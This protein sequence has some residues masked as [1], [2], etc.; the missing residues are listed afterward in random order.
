VEDDDD[1]S[2]VASGR[3]SVGSSSARRER[4]LSP[5]LDDDTSERGGAGG[6]RPA[7][8]HRPPP[9]ATSVTP[10]IEAVV[11]AILGAPL[12]PLSASAGAATAS[13]LA[14]LASSVLAAGEAYRASVAAQA[15]REAAVPMVGGASAAV[16]SVSVVAGAADGAAF[17]WAAERDGVPSAASNGGSLDGDDAQMTS[18]AGSAV[19]ASPPPWFAGPGA[20]PSPG[21]PGVGGGPPGSPFGVVRPRRALVAYLGTPLYDSSMPIAPRGGEAAVQ[22]PAPEAQHAAAEVPPGGKEGE[23]AAEGRTMLVDY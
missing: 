20:A 14:G 19:A 9:P 2:T 12:P 15:E 10:A 21:A 18:G 23:E 8:R 1:A 3:A 7:A 17:P 5:A 11:A 4:L 6:F 16:G 22:L 13:Y